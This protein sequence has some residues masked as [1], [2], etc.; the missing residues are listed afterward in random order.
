MPEA[1]DE[2]AP[3]LDEAGRLISTVAGSRAQVVITDG[4]ADPAGAIEA[5]QR[6]RSQGA[7]VDVVG[8]GTQS[9]APVP[10][11]DG[12]FQQD[13]QGESLLSRLPVDQLSAWPRPAADV[14]LPKAKRTY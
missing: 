10:M 3:A 13:L 12:G 14:M 5:A 11:K 4:I 7:T 8:I 1:G 2:L 6:L 9:G